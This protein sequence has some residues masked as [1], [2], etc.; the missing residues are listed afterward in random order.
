MIRKPISV[1][2]LIVIFVA[3]AAVGVRLLVMEKP[4]GNDA[5][6]ST[7]Q[8]STDQ[9]GSST[10]SWD[11]FWRRDTESRQAPAST[12]PTQPERPDEAPPASAAQSQDE[13]FDPYNQCEALH[14]TDAWVTCTDKVDTQMEALEDACDKYE[15]EQW[16]ECTEAA[17]RLQP[18]TPS[19]P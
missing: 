8:P 3:L 14:E 17:E 11:S 2:S 7:V 6:S 10:P 15:D 5:Q 4:R 12:Q 19:Q 9:P 13:D 16:I 1:L 18:Y